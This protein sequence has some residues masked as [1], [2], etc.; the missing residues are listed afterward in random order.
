VTNAPRLLDANLH[1]ADS[2]DMSNIVA[3]L[4]AR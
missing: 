3:Q 4:C 2:K 1:N